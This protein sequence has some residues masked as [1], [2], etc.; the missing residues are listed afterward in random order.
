MQLLKQIYKFAIIGMLVAMPAAYAATTIWGAPHASVA[1]TNRIPVDTSGVSGPGYNSVGDILGLISGDCTMSGS[2]ITCSKSG[3]VSFQPIA[4]SGSASDLSTG[5]VPAARL[6]NPSASSLGGIQSAAAQGSKWIDSISIAG[7]PHLSQVQDTDLLVTDTV[8]NNATTSAHGFLKKLSNN[9]A[10]FMDGTGNWSSPSAFTA[11]KFTGDGVVLS[12]TPSAGPFMA[13]TLVAATAKSLLGNGTAGALAPTYET[14]PTV[15]G[16]IT[17]DQLV[18]T[19]ATGTAPLTVSSTTN[20][21]N[22]NASS[23]GGATFAAPGP[24]GSGTASTGAFT[25]LSATGQFTST[26][27]TGT[28]PFSVSSTTAVTNLSIGGNAATA[29]TAGTLTG[30]LGAN[31][32]LGSLTAV[33]PT[34]QTVPS[35]STAA[36]AL[37]WGSGTGFACNSSITANTATTATTA[38]NATNTAI[39]EDT[40]T[41]ASMFPTW[42][43]AN[44]GNLPQKT[45]STK[46]TFNPSTGVLAAT[47]FSGAGTSLTGTA[48]SLT[49]GNVTTNANLTGPITSVG[50]AVASLTA[51]NVLTGNGTSAITSVAPS[52]SGNVLT[53]NGTDWTSAAPAGGSEL[54][55]IATGTASSSSTLDFTSDITSTYNNYIF[56]IVDILPSTSATFN[57]SVSSNNGSTYIGTFNWQRAAL[58]L[59]SNTAPSYL[60]GTTPALAMAATTGVITGTFYLNGPASNAWNANGYLYDAGN[61]NYIQTSM[62]GGTV[63]TTNA[64]RFAPSAGNFT[65]GVIYMY[66]VKKT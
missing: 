62:G 44:T 28:A 59:G 31:Q 34:G 14:S 9:V 48:A 3:G 20:V 41:N 37:Q 60:G 63:T 4:T 29:T 26:L 58:A 6:P 47:T 65:S 32:V 45:T 11:I 15:S 16:T 57:I 5:T 10:Q 39:T 17:A 12:A 42:V 51:H 22:L 25:T 49:A 46:L 64:V 35:C 24:I 38:T 50:N 56:V 61:G 66:G 43:T 21:A 40:A 13:D 18:S 55:L 36:S 8:G 27:A 54:V 52:T 53:S 23:L 2:T 33:A 30:A 7:V 19:V 1:T